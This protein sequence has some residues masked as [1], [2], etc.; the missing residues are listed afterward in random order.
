VLQKDL[1]NTI[2][3]LRTS[4]DVRLESGMRTKADFG[5]TILNLWVHALIKVTTT[6]LIQQ[7][8]GVPRGFKAGN[9]TGG[10]GDQFLGSAD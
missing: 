3:T 10:Q 8:V 5:P 1:C 9:E 4:R 7:I 2:G 6:G